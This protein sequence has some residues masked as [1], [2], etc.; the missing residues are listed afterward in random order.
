[1]TT[2]NEVQVKL[3]DGLVV[4]GEL[5]YDFSLRPETVG[6]MVTAYE[7]ASP[8]D[9]KKSA[10]RTGVEIFAYRLKPVGCEVS[11]VDPSEMMYMT[12]RDFEL[13]AEAD[14]RL[15]SQLDQ[16]GG[17]PTKKSNT[18]AAGGGF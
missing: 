9:S 4:C 14:R 11:R 13:L 7:N 10:M 2:K 6:D 15:L 18:P 12:R 5:C 17:D 1:M 16:P 8:E 3:K